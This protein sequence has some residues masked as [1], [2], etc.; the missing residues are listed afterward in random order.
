MPTECTRVGWQKR[1]RE[2]LASIAWE[3]SKRRWRSLNHA[4][5]KRQGG[6][7][8]RVLVEDSQQEGNMIE[9]NTQESVQ[10]AIWDN[11]H[12]MRFRLTEAA[13]ICLDP[14]LREAFVYNATTKTAQAILAGTYQYPPNFDQA[15][16]E[17]CEEYSH[18]CLMIPQDSVCTHLSKEDWQRQW[19][20]RWESTSSS[21][22]GLHFSHYI[23]GIQSDHISHF[24]AL[25]ATLIMNRGIVLDRWAR[26][27]SVMLE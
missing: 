26:G 16:K 9:Y 17:I 21:K 18:T 22:S 11:I 10:N 3:K 14:T 23:A 5:G 24:Q 1:E 27:L 8:H 4:M 6:A 25:K 12:C 7:L 2:I 20:G 19:K 13:P 15:T